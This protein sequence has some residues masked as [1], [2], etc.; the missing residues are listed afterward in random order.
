MRYDVKR[1][2]ADVEKY[3]LFDYS[4]FEPYGISYE[5]F[6]AF[7]G[8]YLRYPLK[9]DYPSLNIS[10]ISLIHTSV[11]FSDDIYSPLLVKF[12]VF[13]CCTVMFGM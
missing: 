9:K 8:Q 10:L 1:F 12:A 11:G 5:T 7:N 3:G 6:T 4:V 13:A 2:K